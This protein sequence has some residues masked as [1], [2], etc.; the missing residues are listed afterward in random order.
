MGAV[1][2]QSDWN[3]LNGNWDLDVQCQGTSLFD[4]SPAEQRVATHSDHKKQFPND[5]SRIA[6]TQRRCPTAVTTGVLLGL[7]EISTCFRTGEKPESHQS[8]SSFTK[9]DLSEHFHSNRVIAWS[10][11]TRQMATSLVLSQI[12]SKCLYIFVIEWWEMVSGAISFF[13]LMSWKKHL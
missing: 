1:E 10:I 7:R 9:P 13:A 12:H 8:T 3:Q 4:Y 2:R 6:W 11:C 5:W